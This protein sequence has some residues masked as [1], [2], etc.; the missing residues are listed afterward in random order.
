[1]SKSQALNVSLPSSMVSQLQETYEFSWSNSSIKYLGINITPKIK[2]LYQANYPPMYRKLEADLK[3]WESH[4]IAWIGRINS[5]K[6]TLL[7]RLL[8]LFR[9]LPIPIRRDHLKTFQGKLNK[10]I[11]NKKGSRLSNRNLFNLPKQGGL[12]FPSY[13]TIK[14]F[15]KLWKVTVPKFLIHFS[16]CPKW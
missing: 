5:V 7:P 6:M 14:Q 12:G 13:G 10:F 4:N 9:S 1:M 11:W 15:M 8:Y 2:N 16:N 3:T